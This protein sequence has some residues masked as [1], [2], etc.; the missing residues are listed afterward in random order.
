[1]CCLAQTCSPRSILNGQALDQQHEPW[2]AFPADL[3]SMQRDLDA[4]NARAA[5]QANFDARLEAQTDLDAEVADAYDDDDRA[6]EWTWEPDA[7]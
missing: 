3:D 2:S 7:D 4:E 1:M 6:G 5:T